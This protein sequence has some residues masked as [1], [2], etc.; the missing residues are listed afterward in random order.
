MSNYWSLVLSSGERDKPQR[1]AEYVVETGPQSVQKDLAGGFT[2]LQKYL[3]YSQAVDAREYVRK[4]PV[5]AEA[6]LAGLI[7][8]SDCMQRLNISLPKDPP[9]A[10]ACEPPGKDF[11]PVKSVFSE[12]ADA[13]LWVRKI[14]S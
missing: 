4:H 3:K 11:E 2:L 14:H 8:L 7:A 9:A 12:V 13:K 6:L 5:L 1:T 10:T